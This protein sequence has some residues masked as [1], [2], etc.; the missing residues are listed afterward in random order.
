MVNTEKMTK[1]RGY[2]EIYLKKTK[3]QKKKGKT[4]LLFTT[5]NSTI[6]EAVEKWEQK[7]ESINLGNQPIEY[8]ER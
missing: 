7:N 4:L 8:G 5:E 6:G 1:Y 3:K 2:C